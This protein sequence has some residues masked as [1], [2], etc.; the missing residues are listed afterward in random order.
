MTWT[1]RL[2]GRT[3]AHQ[4]SP[5]GDDIKYEWGEHGPLVASWGMALPAG[6]IHPMLVQGKRVEI[7]YSGSRVWYGFLEEPDRDNWK[8]TA[9]GTSELFND[10]AN[11]SWDAGFDP[12]MGNSIY[13]G[14][15]YAIGAEGTGDL[16]ADVVRGFDFT[17][18]GWTVPG[19]PNAPDY[20]ADM[21]T[22]ETGSTLRQ[23]LDDFTAW[24]G[25]RWAVDENGMLFIPTEPTTPTRAL[26]P[27]VPGVGVTLENYYSA[28]FLK[29]LDHFEGDVPVYNTVWAVSPD[30]WRWGPRERTLEF[31]PEIQI[32]EG[33]AQ[34][35]VDTMQDESRAAPTLSVE[36][37]QGQFITLGGTPVAL[38]LLK[39]G[40]MVAHYGVLDVPG[41]R[42]VHEWVINH[43]AMDT[44]TGIATL[45]PRHIAPRTFAQVVQQFAGGE[46]RAKQFESDSAA[47]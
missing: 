35:I 30:A 14:A 20:D 3:W 17:V 19:S 1:I 28:T 38:P 24:T 22:P 41:A 46:K 43:F 33:A 6:F 40:V 27:G 26:V 11:L 2:G 21:A 36:L 16:P 8:C 32:T 39:T 44:K 15:R 13:N 29:Y 45:A 25:R 7:F 23:A 42:N 4:I 5:V 31:D 12:E 37:S 10:I 47:A 34:L 9:R 18:D